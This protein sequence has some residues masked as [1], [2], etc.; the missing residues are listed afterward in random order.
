MVIEK[1]EGG[2]VKFL[3]ETKILFPYRWMFHIDLML[4]VAIRRNWFR[5][6]TVKLFSGPSSQL[7]QAAHSL[8]PPLPF[9]G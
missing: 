3:G 1:K 8:T 4:V 2:R 9:T 5:K 6:I 7:Q